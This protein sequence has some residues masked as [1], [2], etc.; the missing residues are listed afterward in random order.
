MTTRS[1]RS[2][3][4]GISAALILLLGFGLIVALAVDPNP[5]PARVPACAEDELIVGSGDYDGDTGYWSGY[6]CV[7]LDELITP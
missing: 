3:L 5:P 1:T 7:H 2:D 4:F 6:A